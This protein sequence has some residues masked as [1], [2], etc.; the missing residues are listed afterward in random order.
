M[1][2]ATFF[3]FSP[4]STCRV[5][6]I[7]AFLVCQTISLYSQN[8]V[9]DSLNSLLP[10]AQ[11][12]QL[13]DIDNRLAWEYYLYD[14]NKSSQHSARAL[15]V[16]EQLGYQKG[17]C[18]ASIYQ[19]LYY[20]VKG[21]QIKGR[22]LL[23]RGYLVAKQAGLKGLEGYALIQLGNLHRNSGRYDS[24]QYFYERSYQVLKDS[25]NPWYLGSLYGNLS[26][27][28]NVTSRPQLELTYLEKAYKI[29]AKLHD[30]IVLVDVLVLLSGWY[31]RA[32]DLD[33]AMGYLASAEKLISKE[34]PDRIVTD[35][36]NRKATILSQQGNYSGALK[37]F[38]EVKEYYNHNESPQEY[39]R[40]LTEIG[41]TFEQIGDYE[42]SQQIYFQALQMAEKRKFPLETIK[43]YIRSAWNHYQLDQPEFASGFIE[44]V[45]AHPKVAE[46]RTEEAD[47]YNLKGVLADNLG[48]HDGA[49]VYF[50]KALEIRTALDDKKGIAA[51][52]GN[53]G[54]LM[55]TKGKFHE[56]LQ[57]HTKSLQIDESISN[58]AGIAWSHLFLGRVQMK[59]GNFELAK[60]LLQKAERESKTLGMLVVLKL[61]YQNERDLL[62]MQ[63][64]L[65]GALEYSRLFE[66][67]QDSVFRQSL[68]NRINNLQIGYQL[69]QKNKE[70][71]I[72]NKDREIQ[73]KE[74]TIQ[75]DQLQKQWLA[76]STVT[77]ILIFLGFFAVILYRSNKKVKALNKDIQERNQKIQT[78]SEE[79]VAANN[80]LT[81]IN[82][83]LEAKQEEILAQNEELMQAN[84]EIAAQRDLLN[85]QNGEL[86]TMRQ[87]VQEQNFEITAQNENLEREVERRTHDLVGYS[88]QLEQFAFMAS[89]NLRAPVARILGLGELLKLKGTTEADEEMIRTSLI[90]STRDLDGVVKDL[91]TVL[92][93]NKGSTF[94]SEVHLP[95]LLHGICEI[96]AEEI[97]HTGTVIESNFQELPSVRSS[98]PYLN[99]ILGNL[100]SNA[101]KYR[102]PYRSPHI[103]IQSKDLGELVCIRVS[104]N[105][106]GIDLNLYREKLF[107]LYSRFHD[108]VEGK[109]FGLYLVK[110]QVAALGGTIEV[111]SQPE[112]GTTFFVYLKK[113]K[114]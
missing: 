101:V 17:I 111:E 110:T 92:G 87:L 64:N 61:A 53:L 25:L 51:T 5:A 97:L 14:F 66:K 81:S 47:A 42:A 26:K 27:L 109:G 100:I 11:G 44:K 3:G 28:Y 39:V 98:R 46:Y 8:S 55:E 112:Q 83:N 72:I 15:T 84:E 34:T 18:Q 103:T 113:L 102:H 58:K 40:L 1:V 36:K 82:S 71:Q 43:L 6:S 38:E 93:I 35:I 49:E 106:L 73:K 41:Y 75:K 59:L 69:D 16:A 80:S 50:N 52:L 33:K 48:D 29:R 23:V 94:L 32:F 31:S 78:Q 105:G 79:L 74:L 70:I 88:R 65:R 114:S 60:E 4:A 85:K 67:T 37:L 91:N 22:P 21:D 7:I 10:A 9:I 95:E 90:K 57:L 76:I 63:G 77:T 45:L 20:Y 56:A 107:T 99:S 24:A 96:M 13:V 54:D 86:K 12:K 89:H 2:A 62:N 19:G 108:H 30:N 68:N 104:D